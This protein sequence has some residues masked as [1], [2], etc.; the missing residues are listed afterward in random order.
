MENNQEA[1]ALILQELKQLEKLKT[2]DRIMESLE[3]TKHDLKEA[4]LE[5]ESLKAKVA[6]VEQLEERLMTLEN[7]NKALEEKQ[8]K[9]EMNSRRENILIKGVKERKDENCYHIAQSL[10]NKLGTGYGTC[11]LQRAHRLGNSNSNSQDPRPIIVRF[12]SYQEKMKIMKKRSLLRDDGIFLTDDLLPEFRTKRQA[13]RPV[14]KL[15]AKA[16]DKATFSHDKLKYK[17]Q[18]YSAETIHKIPLDTTSIGMKATDDH[19]FFKGQ[20]N[21]LSNL[22]NHELHHNGK[23]FHSAEQIYQVEKATALGH[24]DIASKVMSASTPYEAMLEGKK[25]RGT[26]EWTETTGKDLMVSALN[27]KLTQVDLFKQFLKLGKGKTF[28]EA[29]RDAVWG[30]GVD[31]YSTNAYTQEWQG[32]NILGS[33]LTHMANELD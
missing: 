25:A 8:D 21:P 15:T 7:R 4:W 9:H 5:I 6:R 14:V 12:L 32:K 2:L 11:N 29:T 30:S 17:G 16:T 33:I 28:V 13:L 24:H 1:M 26:E 23:L 10:F 31:F 18:L 3:H 19:I 20:Y 22:Y 27:I